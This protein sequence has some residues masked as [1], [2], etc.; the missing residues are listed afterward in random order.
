MLNTIQYIGLSNK[1]IIYKI[2]EYYNN[3]L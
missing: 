2:G 1:K 3:I